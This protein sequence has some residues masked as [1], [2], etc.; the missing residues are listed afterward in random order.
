MGE[1][2]LA[3]A[4][5][6]NEAVTRRSLYYFTVPFFIIVFSIRDGTHGQV[7]DS[8]AY[9]VSFDILGKLA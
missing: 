4:S 7:R 5:W 6:P 8:E 3:A 9:P 2:V 1:D